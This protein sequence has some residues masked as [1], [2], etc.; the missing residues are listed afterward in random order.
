MMR[1]SE[2]TE[3]FD[4]GDF[5]HFISISLYRDEKLMKKLQETRVNLSS[6]PGAE[7]LLKDARRA[8][9]PLVMLKLN[10]PAR[11]KKAI[12]CMHNSESILRL[13]ADGIKTF[14]FK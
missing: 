4:T 7:H 14:S 1:A 13:L 9:I 3:A 10:T 2:L 12:E 6:K 11:Q 5:S 8:H